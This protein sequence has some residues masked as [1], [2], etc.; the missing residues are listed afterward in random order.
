MAKKET[1]VDTIDMDVMP[2][3]D[4]ITEED[5]APFSVD[6]NFDNNDEDEVEFPKEAEIEEISETELTT[7]PEEMEEKAGKQEETTETTDGETPEEETMAEESAVNTQE[8]L[9]TDER[10]VVEPKIE[11]K[12]PMVPKSRLDEV[13][14]KQKALQKQLNDAQAVKTTQETAPDYDFANKETQYQD[15]VLN[16]E[17]EKAVLLRSEMRQAEKAQM[18]H[19]VRQE[20]GQTVQQNQE[21]VD[22]QVKAEQIYKEHPALDENNAVY[23]ANLQNE[24][25]ELRDAFVS[26]GYVPVDALSKATKYVMGSGIN[27][28]AP[29]L[30]AVPS[31]QTT[32]RQEATIKK[33]VAAS[34][35][36][37]PHLKGEGV[38]AKKDVKLDL[39]NLST[40]E[41]NALPAETLRRMRGDFG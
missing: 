16:G 28:P 30:E 31:P 18:M 1:K 39:N 7:T 3:A 34:E 12:A 15:L 20:M 17:S 8:S 19:E 38:N 33:K 36:Q 11:E 24:V 5:A 40:E 2:G 13:L 35:S 26:K 6:L 10:E 22:L 23:D 27:V 14:A 37:P 32:Q 4:P 29:V 9:S 25:L 21:L 41:F